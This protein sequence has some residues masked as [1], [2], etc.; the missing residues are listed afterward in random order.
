MSMFADFGPP[1]GN[2]LVWKRLKSNGGKDFEYGCRESDL[3][4]AIVE[5]EKRGEKAPAGI[6]SDLLDSAA[7]TTQKA[8]AIPENLGWI[9]VVWKVGEPKWKETDQVVKDEGVSRYQLYYNGH[10][11]VYDYTLEFTNTSGWDFTFLDD[12]R[13]SYGIGTW[14]N[15]TIEFVKEGAWKELLSGLADR[16]AIQAWIELL[17]VTSN[18]ILLVSL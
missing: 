6:G 10:P 16:K 2:G 11:N 14:L 12:S 1:D 4:R 17:T 18:P 8:D 15:G 13:D 3:K 5:H 7:A 9:P